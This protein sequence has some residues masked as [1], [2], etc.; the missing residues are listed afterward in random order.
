MQNYHGRQ[1]PSNSKLNYLS[2]LG[3]CRCITENSLAAALEIL[4]EIS[5]DVKGNPFVDQAILKILES[6]AS[7]L[8]FL[9][10]EIKALKEEMKELNGMVRTDL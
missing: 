2:H 4:S 7:D 10:K 6:I 1:R 5:G 3:D 8:V 9:H